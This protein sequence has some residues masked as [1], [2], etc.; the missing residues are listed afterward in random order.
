MYIRRASLV[1]QFPKP[2]NTFVRNRRKGTGQG[3]GHTYLGIQD[4]RS[5]DIEVKYPGAT[6]IPD[7][8]KIFEPLRDQQSVLVAFALQE[9]ISRDGCAQADVIYVTSMVENRNEGMFDSY[10]TYR[11]CRYPEPSLGVCFRQSQSRE[12]DGYLPWGRLHNL[13]G[14]V[15]LCSKLVREGRRNCTL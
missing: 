5:L 10:W 13:L 2:A 14:P 9:S 1:H 11:S 8:K 4:A 3:R 15:T 6:L 12:R 7:E